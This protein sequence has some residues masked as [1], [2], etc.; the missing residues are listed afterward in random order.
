MRTFEASGHI[1]CLLAL[2]VFGVFGCSSGP[3]APDNDHPPAWTQQS[4][5]TVDNGYIVYVGKGEDRSLDK[6]RF[7]GEAM[8]LQDL[9]NECSLPPKGARVEDHFDQDVGILHRSYVKVAVEFQLC[10]GAKQA[11]TPEQIRTLANAQMSEEVKKYQDLYDEPEDEEMPQALLASN[12]N[13]TGTP[14]GSSSGG[15]TTV[16]RSASP[17]FVSSGPQY[18]VVSQ[19]VAYVKQTV[20]LAPPTQY[21]PTAPATTQPVAV[22]VPQQR[23]LSEYAANNPAIKSSPQAFSTARPN[24]SQHSAEALRQPIAQRPSSARR[25]ASQATPH[26][27]RQGNSKSSGSGQSKPKRRRKREEH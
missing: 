26:V 19:Q 7:K 23:A 13:G 14:S 2:A 11:V 6:S 21:P 15:G 16:Y 10:E 9:V 12:T 20:I 17:I 24:W 1:F 3:Q 25:N 27:N 18:Y 8:G 22:I 5:R 4:T